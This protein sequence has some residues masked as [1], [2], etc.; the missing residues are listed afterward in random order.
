MIL[1][2]YKTQKDFTERK[3]YFDDEQFFKTEDDVVNYL[4][5]KRK[6]IGKTPYYLGFSSKRGVFAIIISKEMIKDNSESRVI[7]EVLKQKGSI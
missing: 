1:R 4:E 5:S 6:D 7:F 2:F 3:A